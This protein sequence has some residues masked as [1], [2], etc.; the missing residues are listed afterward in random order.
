VT[1]II[2][3]ILPVFLVASSGYAVRR[4]V[5]LDTKTLSALNL[6]IF[7]PSLVFASLSERVLPWAVF[8]RI[9]GASVLMVVAMMVVLE[10]LARRRKLEGE[11]HS[12]FLMTMFPNLGNFSLPVCKFAFGDEGLAMALV[13][14]VCGSFLQNSLG[15]YFAQRAFSSAG[16][17]FRRVLKFPMIYAFLLALVFQRYGYRLP[18]AADRAVKI[19][20]DAAIPVQLMILG[21][22][23]A[24]TRLDTSA[25]VFLA[26]AVRL[27]LGP[28]FAAILAIAVGLDNITA[29]A[30]IM[31][32]SA[33]VAVGMTAYG[34]QFDVAPRFLASVVAWTFLLSIVTVSIVLFVLSRVSF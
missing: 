33:P 32:M 22:Q 13:V 34:A 20:A 4:F 25:N 18:V 27:G 24:A 30:F 19:T 3:V 29:K 2:S 10:A 7:I 17:S 5:P 12:A 14:M 28:I 16:T 15:L 6:Y 8:G 23:L 26:S 11:D 31:Q 21:I 1:E 9:A